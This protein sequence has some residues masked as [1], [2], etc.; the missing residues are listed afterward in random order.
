MTMRPLAA[1]LVSL[2]AACLDPADGLVLSPADE[3]A[4]Q[5][6]SGLAPPLGDA[7]TVRSATV[8]GDRLELL[9]F[10]GG[11]R[12]THRFA[13]GNDGQQGLSLPPYLTVFV[14]HDGNGDSCERAVTRTLTVDLRPLRTVAG[15]GGVVLLRIVEPDGAA[16]DVGELRYDF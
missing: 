7:L 6:V 9:V 8:T 16:A 5:V 10:Y 15:A 13:F 1:V 2:A 12:E 14:A 11:G 4:V 3:Q